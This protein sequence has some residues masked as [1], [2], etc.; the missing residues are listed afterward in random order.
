MSKVSFKAKQGVYLTY[1]NYPYKSCQVFSEYIDNAIQSFEG[2]KNLLLMSDPN[3]K[4]RVDIEFDWGLNEDNIVV[5]KEV[6]IQDNAAGMTAQQFNE[7]FDLA[8][9][10]VHRSGMNEFGVGMKAASCWLGNKWKIETTSITDNMSR[11]LDVNLKYVCDNQIDELDFVESR[12]DSG[13]HGTKITISDLWKTNVLKQSDLAGLIKSIASIYRY[14]LRNNEIQIFIGEKNH[15]EDAEMLTFQDYEVLNAPSYLQPNGESIEWKKPVS[16]QDLQ[17]HGI[18]GFIA[19]LKDT[20]GEKRGVVF[21][22]NHRV[23][24]GFDPNDRT[25]GKVFMGQVGSKKYRRVFGELELTGFDVAF[26]KNQIIDTDLLES[27]CKVVAGSLTIQ[28]TNLL[29]QGDK[30]KKNTTKKQEKNPKSQPQEAPE[31]PFPAHTPVPIPE[32]PKSDVLEEPSQKESLPKSANA[33]RIFSSE[34]FKIEGVE[35]DFRMEEGTNS[36]DLFWNDVSEVSKHTL[37]CKVNVDHPFFKAF[38]TPTEQTLAIL[39]T[40][41]MAKYI[42]SQTGNC[43]TMEMMNEFNNLIE[44]LKLQK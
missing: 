35:Y 31:I 43:S 28:G 24:M 32:P 44:T 11:M 5:A 6:T 15:P 37:V 36:K 42:S 14:F 30:Y 2:N 12:D 7:A 41:S 39:R 18:T 13:Y 9:N 25:I 19:L 23:V 26:G 22:R 8:D 38:G 33:N 1:Q 40:L 29:T 16:Y 20:A 3:Y 4:L 10:S 34:K 21:M 27:L 17:G